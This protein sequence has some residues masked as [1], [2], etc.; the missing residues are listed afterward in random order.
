MHS[1]Q[2]LFGVGEG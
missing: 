2:I 1:T